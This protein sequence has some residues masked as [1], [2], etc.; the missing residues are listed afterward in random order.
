MDAAI[1]QVLRGDGDLGIRMAISK[2]LVTFKLA[3]IFFLVIW[4]CAAFDLVIVKKILLD[5]TK[6]FL[7]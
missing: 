1:W 5:M 4:Q 6:L 7:G 2:K 3:H